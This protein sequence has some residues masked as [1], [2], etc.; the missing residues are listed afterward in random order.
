MCSPICPPP[1]PPFFSQNFFQAGVDDG[2]SVTVRANRGWTAGNV[3]KLQA[4]VGCPPVVSIRECD[5]HALTRRSPLAPAQLTSTQGQSFV[6]LE[7]DY[8]GSDHSANIKALNPSPSDGTGIYIVNFL[9]S[10]TRNFALGVETIYQRPSVDMEEAST[11]YMAKYT[12]DAR[13]WIATAQMQGAGVLQAT[14]WQKLSDKVDIAADLQLLAV[15]QRREAVA[16]LGSR[17]DF[18]MANFRAQVDST[19]KVSALL[20]QRFTPIFGFTVAGEID[21]FKVS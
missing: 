20:E 3:S 19:G 17:W 21:H 10:L 15:G 12:S 11:G 16:T 13:D 2:G 4:Q 5:T 1:P 6:Q 9:Q 8:Q 7:H 14:Y 18:R